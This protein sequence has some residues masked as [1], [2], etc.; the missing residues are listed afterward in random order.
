MGPGNVV[1][2]QPVAPGRTQQ[3]EILFLDRVLGSQ[4]IIKTWQPRQRDFLVAESVRGAAGSDGFV[5][6]RC[7]DDKEEHLFGIE[8]RRKVVFD[9]A[10]LQKGE[11][12]AWDKVFNEL[13]WV[14]LRRS[15]V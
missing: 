14:G 12:P 5:F 3:E 4:E 6:I 7:A 10:V 13:R 2:N 8:P 15:R 1:L 11:F 9:D